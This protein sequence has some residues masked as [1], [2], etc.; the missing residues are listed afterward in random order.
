MKTTV[1]TS[2]EVATYPS[3][4]FS[5]HLSYRQQKLAPLQVLDDISVTY[6]LYSWCDDYLCISLI[7]WSLFHIHKTAQPLLGKQM[8]VSLMFVP[9][10]EQGLVLLFC[11]PCLISSLNLALCHLSVGTEKDKGRCL[12]LIHLLKKH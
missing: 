7:Q 12:F 8:P 9:I 5:F 3:I 11:S 10:T 1:W 2:L 4:Y 6:P